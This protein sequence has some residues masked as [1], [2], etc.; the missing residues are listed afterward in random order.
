MLFVRA[1]MRLSHLSVPLEA[2]Y[3]GTEPLAYKPT[4][5]YGSLRLHS[6]KRLLFVRDGL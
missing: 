1:S 3:I 6:G 5:G 2:E 4:K